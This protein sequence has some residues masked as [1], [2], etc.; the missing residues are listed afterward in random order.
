[1]NDDNPFAPQGGGAYGSQSVG[2]GG[3]SAP[4]AVQPGAQQ[5]G[6]SLSDSTA[7]GALIGETTTAGFQSDV[8]AESRNQPVLVDFWAPWCGP[9]KQLTPVIE[10]AVQAAAGKVKLVKMNIDDH[11]S[12]AGQM[13]IQS[14]PAVIAFSN[15]QPV[16]GFMG[17]KPE[18]EVK[19]FIEKLLQ[20]AGGARAEQEKAAIVEALQQAGQAVDAGDINGAAQIYSMVLQH[21]PDNGDAYGGMAA[22]MVKSGQK[23]KAREML[24]NAPDSLKDHPALAA[25]VAQL[26]L[27]DKLAEIGDPAILAKRLEDDPKDHEARFQMA[28][29]DNA[30]G[31]RDAAAE[32]L[33]AIMKADREW[34]D[35][36]A[37]KELLTFFE[38]WGPTDPATV[39]ARRKLSSLLFR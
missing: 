29:I 4:Q 36:G 2:F 30:R 18:S 7:P 24:D 10:A 20:S 39:S 26:A 6:L 17:A 38:A 37:R 8:I 11:P 19:A 16:D 34:R 35:D 15:G 23:D 33:L 1:M 14:I 12:I 32:G 28:Q 3:A 22:L 31:N 9:C 25:V 27:E 21:D 13:G 5:P